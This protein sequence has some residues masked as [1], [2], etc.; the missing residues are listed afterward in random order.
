V[1]VVVYIQQKGAG[2]KVF[3]GVAGNQSSEMS[4]GDGQNIAYLLS[5][6]LYTKY[7]RANI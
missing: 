2:S 6:E 3:K 7:G 4:I 5:A 1:I